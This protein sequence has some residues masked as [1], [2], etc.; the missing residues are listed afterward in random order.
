M[1]KGMSDVTMLCIDKALIVGKKIASI[2]LV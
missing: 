1:P 2:K